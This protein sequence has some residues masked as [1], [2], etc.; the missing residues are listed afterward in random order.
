VR[1]SSWPWDRTTPLYSICE[2]LQLALGQ[3]YTPV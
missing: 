2:E 1:S 3:D